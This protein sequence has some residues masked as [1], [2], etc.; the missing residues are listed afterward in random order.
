MIALS[1][2]GELYDFAADLTKAG[3]VANV[4]AAGVVRHHAALLKTRI[5][6]HASGRP[7]PRAIT[8]DYRRS[9]EMTFVAGAGQVGAF[10]GTNKPQGRRLE[11]GF[12]GTDS[13]NRHVNAP[14]YPHVAP[15]FA[16]TWPDFAESMADVGVPLGLL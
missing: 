8:G 15:A 11:L 4:K 12:V 7:G 10:V 13:L 2:A 14:P 16:E 5:Q 6:A 1:G 3:V 9:W